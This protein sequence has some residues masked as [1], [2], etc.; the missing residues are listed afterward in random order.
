MSG[1]PEYDLLPDDPVN[2]YYIFTAGNITYS[3]AGHSN[4]TPTLPEAKLFVNTMVASFRA[5]KVKPE[6]GFYASA[7]ATEPISNLVL[8]GMDT[9]AAYASEKSDSQ[10]VQDNDTHFASQDP[11]MQSMGGGETRIYFRI[12]D[13]NL[14]ANKKTG[15]SVRRT[16]IPSRRTS[17]RLTRAAGNIRRGRSGRRSRFT[18]RRTIPR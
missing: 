1:V 2:Q 17:T 15:V 9:T 5:T 7:S 3:G 10:K 6:G 12:K 14:A 4:S 18:R 8:S 11:T 16:R 13:A